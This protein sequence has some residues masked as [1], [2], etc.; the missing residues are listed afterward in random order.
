ME[1]YA[2]RASDALEVALERAHKTAELGVGVRYVRST[3]LPEDEVV[4]HLFEAPSAEALDEA[5]RAADLPFDRIVEAV[6]RSS[7]GR[8]A[9]R[10][11]ER[12]VEAVDDATRGPA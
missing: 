7:E 3:Y 9:R 2:A 11:I 4:F 12:T 5:G 8:D 10:S 1:S 6:E